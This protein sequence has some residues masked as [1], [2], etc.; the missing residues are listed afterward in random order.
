MFI[1]HTESQEFAEV[2]RKVRSEAFPLEI[3]IQ[4]RICCVVSNAGISPPV[5][6][7]L[8]ENCETHRRLI[9]NIFLKQIFSFG[10]QFRRKHELA[11]ND[12]RFPLPLPERLPYI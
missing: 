9:V 4:N 3:R 10:S 1:V 12:V 5:K 6:L 8:I 11:A 7:V 2:I